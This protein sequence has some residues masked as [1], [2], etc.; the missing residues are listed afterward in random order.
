MF[1]AVL[2]DLDGTLLDIDMNVF[3]EHYFHT[4]AEMAAQSGFQQHR[5]L[6]EQVFQS[7]GVMIADRDPTSTNQDIFMNDFFSRWPYQRHEFE[8][9]FEHFYREGFPRLSRLC[10]PIPGV[11]EL[12]KGMANKGIQMVVA[13]NAV[14]PLTALQQRLQW[15]GLEADVFDLIT[16]YEVMHFCKPH[17]EYYQEICEKLQLKPQDCLMVGND[18]G[19]DMVAEKL[20]MKT[21]LVEDYVID[22]GHT[23][24]R[25]TWRGTMREFLAFASK[26]L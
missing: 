24:I 15:A 13:T 1:K 9:F 11:P 8:P 25:P 3:L 7:T 16:S 2:F 19:E 20:G 14:F 17:L 4:M 21:F 23:D 12:I 5:Q 22:P 10:R 18:V 26:N 6:V